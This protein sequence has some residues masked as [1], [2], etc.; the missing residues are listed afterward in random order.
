MNPYPSVRALLG[1][2]FVP[3]AVF[4][5]LAAI[6]L[7]SRRRSGPSQP[8]KVRSDA[9]ANGYANYSLDATAGETIGR[10]G[11]AAITVLAVAI[12]VVAPHFWRHSSPRPKPA[13]AQVVDD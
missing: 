11:Q 4:D 7:A 6:L 1:V 12:V 5:P 10:V 13:S 8:M 9:A 3:L 2:Y